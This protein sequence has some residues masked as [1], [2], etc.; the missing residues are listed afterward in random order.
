MNVKDFV[1]KDKDAQ[2]I[3]YRAMHLFYGVISLADYQLYTFPVP[4][5]DVGTATLMKIEKTVILM[6]WIR[7][8]IEDKTLTKVS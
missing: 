1:A 5:D 8:A 6:R 2:F 3:Y 4:L 7:K